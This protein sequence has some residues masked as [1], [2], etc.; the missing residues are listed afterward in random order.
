MGPFYLAWLDDDRRTILYICAVYDTREEAEIDLAI[1]RIDY[2]HID[3]DR[4]TIIE[5]TPLPQA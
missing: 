4:V 2:P 5:E 3:Y 1:T